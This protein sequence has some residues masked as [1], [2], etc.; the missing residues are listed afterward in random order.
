VVIMTDADVDGSHIRVLLCTL[1][2][3]HFPKLIAS[4]HLY[5]AQPPLYRLDVPGQGKT[6]H[7]ARSMRSTA[8]NSKATIDRLRLEGVKPEAVAD[9]ALQGPRRNESRAALGNDDV[10]RYAPP[11]AHPHAGRE[12]ASPVM[13]ML[14]GKNESAGRRAWMEENGA[15]IGAEI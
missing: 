4:G 14:M 6:V 15:L 9:L 10:A 11:D 8:P 12:T 7:H 3:R 2:Y 1:F 5:F 13:N